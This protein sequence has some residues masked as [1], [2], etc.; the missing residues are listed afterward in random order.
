MVM[1]F[2]RFTCLENDTNTCTCVMI[3]EM[4]VY[5]PD[6]EEGAYS[7]VAFIDSPVR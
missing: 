2:S 4:M 3:D 5:G 1:D 7:D 6:G